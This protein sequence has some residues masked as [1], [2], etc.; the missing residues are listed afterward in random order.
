MG[1]MPGSTLARVLPT[2]TRSGGF[3]P[4]RAYIAASVW[5]PAL[6][7][8]WRRIPGSVP[9][10]NLRSLENNWRLVTHA[11]SLSGRRVLIDKS[12]S[13]SR[14]L[15]ILH[16][17]PPGVIFKVVHLI[18]DGRATMY[19]HNR[20]FGAD[21]IKAGKAW[22]KVNR[23]IEW[24]VKKLPSCQRL[25]LQYENLCESPTAQITDLCRFIG[26]RFDE[27]MLTLTYRAHSIGGNDMRFRGDRNIVLDERWRREL[28][29]KDI[30]RFNRIVGA[31]NHHFGYS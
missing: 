4:R 18:R 11:A 12:M 17:V 1:I 2:E 31:M 26:V 19:S 9:K 27:S 15:D 10:A 3:L 21:P 5:L 8:V 22:I 30:Q 25:Q 6:A 16:T 14:I 28:D 23:N 7:A 24:L 29:G 13:P 20:N